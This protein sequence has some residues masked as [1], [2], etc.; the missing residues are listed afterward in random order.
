M[1]EREYK[2]LVKKT[3]DNFRQKEQIRRITFEQD[4]KETYDLLID[5]AI[6]RKDETKYLEY[7]KT[8]HDLF[9]RK[10]EES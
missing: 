7:L 2:A 9:K 10:N 6:N 4:M 8:K 5:C 1:R 3:F